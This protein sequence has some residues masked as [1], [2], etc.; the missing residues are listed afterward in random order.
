[1][2]LWIADYLGDTRQLSLSEHGAYLLLMFEYWR[3]GNTLPD[4]NAVL[5]RICSATVTE[6][7]TV[8]VAVRAKFKPAVVNG[9][10]VLTHKR[11]E[12]ELTKMRSEYDK[13]VSASVRANKAKAEAAARL[14]AKSVSV[15]VTG[16]VC[17][18]VTEPE[19]V[20]VSAA[21]TQLT[22]HNSS[23]LNEEEKSVLSDFQSDPPTAS[24]PAP[25]PKAAKAAYSSEFE[26]FWKAY[27]TDKNMP[28]LM[29]FKQ[30]VKLSVDDQRAAIAGIVGYRAWISKQKDYRTLHADRFLSQR[31]FDGFVPAQI[32]DATAALASKDKADRMLRRGKYAADED[33]A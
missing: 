8:A 7:D 32:V 28:K 13:R 9:R 2:P 27:P 4:D 16:A 21:V 1:M 29:A 11:I 10:R 6:W 22:T 12:S 5:A 25:K 33:A 14:K 3:T 18:T 20:A 30:W 15:A 23:S 31:R 17:A 19:T 26:E 24:K